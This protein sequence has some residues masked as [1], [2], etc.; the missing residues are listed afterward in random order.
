MNEQEEI[1]KIKQ[2]DLKTYERVFRQ[3]YEMLCNY[4]IM[5][6]KDQDLAEEMVQDIFYRI[7]KKHH[8][9]QISTTLKG[10]LLQSTKNQCLQY[11]RHKTIELKYAAKVKKEIDIPVY[12]PEETYESKEITETINLTLQQLPDKCREVFTLSRF[13]GL[14]YHEIADKMSI[15]IK[16][17]EAYMG[18]AL[19]VFREKLSCYT[20][21]S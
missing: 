19:K 10:Y 15:S 20:A 7:W 11:L 6:V 3:Y 1:D 18:K 8:E 9:I 12:Q 4:A 2:G 17:V 16:S 5:F 21:M 14:K 13:E